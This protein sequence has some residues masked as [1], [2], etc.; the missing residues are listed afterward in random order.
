MRYLIRQIR[1]HELTKIAKTKKDKDK[2]ISKISYQPW[3]IKSGADSHPSKRLVTFEKF[4]QTDQ[5]I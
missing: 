3:E 2:T 1:G 4:N 5:E